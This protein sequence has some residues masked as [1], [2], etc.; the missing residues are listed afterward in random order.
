[1]VNGLSNVF[2]YVLNELNNSVPTLGEAG[3]EVSHFIP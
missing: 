1:M 2:K 3:S